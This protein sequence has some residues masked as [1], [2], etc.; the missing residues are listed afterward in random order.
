MIHLLLIGKTEDIRT[1]LKDHMEKE[2][3][4]SKKSKLISKITFQAQFQNNL[5]Y[6]EW[7]IS[8]V[9]FDKYDQNRLHNKFN[10]RLVDYKV[11]Q[12]IEP[13]KEE[14]NTL[15]TGT[16]APPFSGIRYTDSTSVQLTDFE[17]RLVL[18]DFWYMSCYPC[19]QAI[20]H[21]T[22]IYEKYKDEGLTVLGLNPFDNKEKNR[23]RLP[24]FIK[25]NKLTYPIIFVDKEVTQIYNVRG[26]PTFYIVNKN[27]EI[28]FSQIGFGESMVPKVDSIIQ[29]EL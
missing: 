18:L 15:E 2:F 20:P 5:Q 9:E 3:W 16:V 4:I 26:Y 7:N 19:V 12:Y 22:D 1:R 6:N 17:G 8:K 28:L 11:E 23:K 14:R 10:D 29:A 27:G 21:L 13:N 25:Y 24:E